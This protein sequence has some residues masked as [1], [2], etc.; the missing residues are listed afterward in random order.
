MTQ[1]KPQKN[2][3]PKRILYYS[4]FATLTLLATSAVNLTDAYFVSKLGSVA[5]GA[6]GVAFAVQFLIQ[7]I[8]FTLGMGGG[9]LFSRA[10][11]ANDEARCKQVASLSVFL[12]ILIGV[13]TALIGLL[14]LDNLLLLLGATSAIYPLAKEYLRLLLFSAP[15]ICLSLVQSQLLRAAGNAAFSMIGFTVGGLINLIFTPIFLFRLNLGIAGAGYAMLMGYAVSSLFLFLFSRLK[16]SKVK[17]TFKMKIPFWTESGRILLTG[18]PSFC[19]HGFSGLATLLLNNLV[20]GFGDYAIAAVTVVARISLLALSF[21]T[22]IGQG[23]IPVAGYHYG[24]KDIEKV[25]SAYRFSLILSSIIMLVLSIPIFI[26]AP[27]LI[28][29]FRNEAEIVQIGAQALRAQSTVFVLHGTIT[30]TT[31]LLQVIGHSTAS[32]VLAAARQGIFF[33]PLLFLFPQY[34]RYIQPV[35]DLLTFLLTVYFLKR[36]KNTTEGKTF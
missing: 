10:L 17:L 31:M 33:L 22:G 3:I 14:F 9:S 6:V 7:A 27:Q 36:Y 1:A 8:G 21:S 30:T 4:S 23:M 16:K 20:R 11:G 24:A 26:F 32:T 5:T 12:A 28:A 2:D 13:S 25:R 19:R 29:L 18:L 15:L 35:A 34:F